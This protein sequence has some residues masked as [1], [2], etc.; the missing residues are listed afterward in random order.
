MPTP[1]R[2]Q[3][4]FWPTVA[5]LLLAFGLSEPTDL[6]LWV[7]DHF[8]DFATGK[9]WVDAKAPVPRALFYNGPKFVIILMALGVLGFALGPRRW[10]ER[11]G[12][13]RRRLWAVFI[14]LGLV[15]AFIG[16]IKATNNVYCAYEIHRYGGAVPYVKVLERHPPAEQPERCGK[17]F[18][19]GHASGG[20]ALFAFAGLGASRRRQRLGVAIGLAAGWWMGAYQMLKGAHYLSHTLVTM[21]LAW[22]L[23]LIVQRA[24]GLAA[25]SAGGVA[26]EQ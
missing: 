18:P 7:Q 15:P 10:S 22:L 23:F 12:M 21:L 13:E 17:C 20:F 14:T 5:I 16:Q 24:F 11:H 2:L 8:F 1:Y 9:W 26:D 25:P 6:D 4:T 19:G 3:R